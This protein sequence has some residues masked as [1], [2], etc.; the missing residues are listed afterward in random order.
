M[1]KRAATGETTPSEAIKEAE[2]R[3]KHIFE[4]WKKKLL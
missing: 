2:A 1:F 4:I 3:C